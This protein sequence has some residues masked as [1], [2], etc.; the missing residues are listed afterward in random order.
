MKTARGEKEEI[1][2]D[3]IIYTSVGEKGQI[4]KLVADIHE[5]AIISDPL[6]WACEES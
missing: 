6:L 3:F 4:A 2:K 5:K 1:V